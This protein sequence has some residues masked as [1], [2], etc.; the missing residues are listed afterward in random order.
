MIALVTGGSG[1]GKSAWAEGLACALEP[2]R[3]AYLATMRPGGAEAQARIARHRSLRAG[4]GFYTVECPD[5]PD[6]AALEPGTTALL[7]CMSNLTA[8]TM[9]SPAPPVDSAAHIWAALEK[10][11]ER[12][13]NL[14]VVSN[15]VFSDGIAY[16]PGTMA[17]LAALGVLN[18]RI[19]LRADLAVEVVCGI[20]VP[21]KGGSLLQLPFLRV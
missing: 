18:R 5:G 10:L 12:C 15:E 3:K 4:K 8:N 2:G 21:L 13:G 14:V 19:A 20:P 17:Y 7:E 1:S 9:F 11:M 16:N 6:A